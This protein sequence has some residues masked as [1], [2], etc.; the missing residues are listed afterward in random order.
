M[1]ISRTCITT[2]SRIDGRFIKS[3]SRPLCGLRRGG[4][5]QFE[6]VCKPGSVL[7]S[8][9]S[10][11][12]VTNAL[13][14]PPKDGPGRP[15]VLS[16]VLLRIEF[17][18]SPCY[19]GG[20]GELLPRLS[21]LTGAYRPQPAVHQ[22]YISVAL[23]LKVAFGGRVPAKFLALW[24]PDFPHKRPFGMPARLPGLLKRI[25]YRI[26]VGKSRYD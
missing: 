3:G 1:T 17:T 25:F 15:Y 10:R 16:A 6:Q 11:R 13:K 8:H 5:M 7:S 21:T 14:P 19:Q 20:W 23:F 9:L 22:R 18:A 24:S 4:V 26:V 2:G 12:A